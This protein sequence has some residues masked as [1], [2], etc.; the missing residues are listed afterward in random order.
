MNKLEFFISNFEEF[1]STG[2]GALEE[3]KY[4]SAVNEFFKACVAA[5]DAILYHKLQITATNHKDRF[6]N[7][8]LMDKEIHDILRRAFAIYRRV[9]TSKMSEKDAREVMKIAEEIRRRIGD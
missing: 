1:F 5:A 8:L 3:R 9:Y 4:N 2:K 7:L 6:D